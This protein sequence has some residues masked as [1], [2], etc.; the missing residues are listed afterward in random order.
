MVVRRI[1]RS[2]K[3]HRIGYDEENAFIER[4]AMLILMEIRY[5][6]LFRDVVT[7]SAVTTY[8]FTICNFHFC[9]NTKSRPSASW[10]E[11]L[12]AI[13]VLME[14]SVELD[15]LTKFYSIDLL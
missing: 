1:F 13:E 5:V 9:G 2:E 11:L 10:R 8:I 15:D 14:P 3:K 4:S 6:I 12:R 7:L